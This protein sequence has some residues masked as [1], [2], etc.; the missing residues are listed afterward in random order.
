M[1]KE[2]ESQLKKTVWAYSLLLGG[3]RIAIAIQNF[4]QEN[5]YVKIN[6]D[7]IHFAA[8]LI[9]VPVMVEVLKQAEN[10]E[11]SLDEKLVVDHQYPLDKADD[12]SRLKR[13]TELSIKELLL[14]S[15]LN[16][17]NE[18]ANMLANR[19]TIP[20]VNKRM[21]DLGL[22]N[23]KMSHLMCYV[24]ENDI[25]DT[26]V[27]DGKSN[28]TTAYEISTLLKMIYNGSICDKYYT[29]IMIKILEEFR[30]FGKHLLNVNAGLD[31]T[32][33]QN[34]RVGQKAGTLED[35]IHSIGVIDRAYSIA[36]MISNFDIE[37]VRVEPSKVISIISMNAFLT[38][39][40]N[41]KPSIFE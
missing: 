41:T 20:A 25:I 1:F 13:G 33:P 6:E 26:G 21:D 31:D 38:Y 15:I 32:L 14:Y 24:D 12:V 11:L 7:D 9:K 17:D 39:A 2:L 34:V 37:R 40:K 18:A 4:N 22:H 27:G 16:S 29:N 23:T 8:S 28:T 3:A 35:C 36:V 19:V 10:G 30:G 5:D